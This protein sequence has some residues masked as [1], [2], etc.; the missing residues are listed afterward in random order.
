[1]ILR[2]VKE[3]EKNKLFSIIWILYVCVCNIIW[4]KSIA[5]QG[6]TWWC[7]SLF[8][9]NFSR[10][11]IN[12]LYQ[13][14]IIDRKQKICHQ[15]LN[16]KQVLSLTTVLFKWNLIDF[17][18]YSSVRC[19]LIIL[20]FEDCVLIHVNCP[21][22]STMRFD[23]CLMVRAFIWMEIFLNP[24]TILIKNICNLR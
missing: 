23:K 7:V 2:F 5:N 3:N 14:F 24:Y 13:L 20:R 22:I 18:V 11:F 16:D 19:G 4:K 9:G 1:M 8:K 6:E 15:I 12:S 17:T 21:H 10:F